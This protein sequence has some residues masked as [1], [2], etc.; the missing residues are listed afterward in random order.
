MSSPVKLHL[1]CGD[2]Y[3]SGYINVDLYP[4]N[5]TKIDEVWDIKKVP[6][7]DNSVDEIVA[8]HVI[9]HF[10]ANTGYQVLAEWY[11]VLKPTGMLKIETPDLLSNC[12][13]FISAD[14]N[15]RLY[16]Y[17]NFFSQASITPGQAH[18]FLYTEIQLF[19]ILN[20]LKFSS[21]K[22]VTPW[23]RYSLDTVNQHLFL[24]VEAQK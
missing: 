18:L 1:G 10:D 20:H 3:K 15:R 12:R 13:D 17:N 2:D 19:G 9:E 7:S 5:G 6:H 4:T 14:E 8:S 24:A 23:S 21:V 16:L 11:R 22:R